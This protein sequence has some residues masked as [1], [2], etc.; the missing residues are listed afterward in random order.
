MHAA[1][2]VEINRLTTAEKLQ[3][4]EELWNQLSATEDGLPLPDWHEKILAED[5]A[6]Y[7]RNPQQG[8]S[9]PEVKARIT[10]KP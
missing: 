9:W 3:L 10:G 6:D 4:V 1:L 8:S 2:S 7:S 5:Q